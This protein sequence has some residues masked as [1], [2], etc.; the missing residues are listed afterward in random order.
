[1]GEQSEHEIAIIL[2]AAG[3]SSRMGKSK[4][5]IPIHGETLLEKSV[6]VALQTKSKNII[7]VLGANEGAHRV[8][9]DKFKVSVVYNPQWETGMGSSLKAGLRYLKSSAV[10]FEAILVMVC[11][12]PLLTACH[13]NKLIDHYHSTRKQIIA[14]GY[15]GAMGVPALFDAS[16]LPMLN[17]LDDHHGAKKIIDSSKELV[18]CINFPEGAIDLDTPDDVRKFLDR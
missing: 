9:L 6:K 2:L 7:V 15:S 8:L 18:D 17:E 12:Q 14:S 3:S 13:L 11:D 1:V 10:K 5:L 4:Q 16:M